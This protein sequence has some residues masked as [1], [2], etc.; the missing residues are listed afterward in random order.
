MAGLGSLINNVIKTIN[1]KDHKDIFNEENLNVKT[2]ADFKKYLKK[3]SQD[4]LKM[5]NNEKKGI[6]KYDFCLLLKQKLTNALGKNK[7]AVDSNLFNKYNTFPSQYHL[8]DLSENNYYNT[9]EQLKKEIIEKVKKYNNKKWVKAIPNKLKKQST[10]LMGEAKLK[11][12]SDKNE[13]VLKEMAEENRLTLPDFR[14]VLKYKLEN[15]YLGKKAAD[16]YKKSPKMFCEE[17]Q[18]FYEEYKFNENDDRSEQIETIYNNYTNINT[19]LLNKK[20]FVITNTHRPSSTVES[21]IIENKATL[22]TYTDFKNE[23]QKS[24]Q[25]LINICKNVN[26]TKDAREKWKNNILSIIKNNPKR[27]EISSELKEI[28]NSDVLSKQRDDFYNQL[29]N[30]LD[31]CSFYLIKL[32]NQN[33]IKQTDLCGPLYDFAS[34]ISTIDNYNKIKDIKYDTKFY[35]TNETKDQTENLLKQH[36][37]ERFTNTVLEDIKKPVYLKPTRPLPPTPT[38]QKVLRNIKKPTHPLQPLPPDQ[39]K[40]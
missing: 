10:H 20:E 15:K 35:I 19:I 8:V 32:I 4:L 13:N 38:F 3:K 2:D 14:M 27:D 40:K 7:R 30:Y 9:Y 24:L 31:P 23:F 34:I 29:S 26:K 22:T 11:S 6:T 25:N 12:L 5:V 28:W 33:T 1:I 17:L 21:I 36:Y 16:I 39:I 37:K 18:T